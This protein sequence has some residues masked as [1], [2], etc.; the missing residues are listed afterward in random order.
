MARRLGSPATLAHVL[1]SRPFAIGSP[2]TLEERL[3]NTA[4]LLALAERLDD[5]VLRCRSHGGRFRA[6]VE[7]GEIEQ[8]ELELDRYIEL[9]EEV[10]QPTL[11]W[12]AGLA[13]VARHV[14]H[15]RLAEAEREADAIL[16]LGLAS[17]QP[18]ARLFWTLH[19]FPIHLDR[20]RMAEIEDLM[21]EFRAALPN[22]PAW[23]GLLALMYSEMGRDGDV[24]RL[25]AL[26]KAAGSDFHL[27]TTWLFGMAG[28]AG[29]CA[30]VEDR[31][32]A[33]VLLERLAP[34][35][36]L[37]A[38]SA[39]GLTLGSVVHST[40]M[41]AAVLG[42]FDEAD[43]DFRAAEAIHQR[44]GAPAWL[45]RTRLER[46]RALL[47]RG[48]PEDRRSATDLLEL[49]VAAAVELALPVVERRGR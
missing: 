26:M 16:E 8:A 9:S 39:W 42:R 37:L 33:A 17:G 46:A 35:G 31:D 18:D 28:F 15:C 19:Q 14:L 1:V 38:T 7:K 3:G 11:R 40:A 43:A 6:L 22:L 13:K 30:V 2:D 5:P 21:L 20:G 23:D 47:R 34:Y 36:S 10:G 41:L 45:A 44:I 29:A 4:D 27:D 48:A 12:M 25:L 24:R 49:A 32:A